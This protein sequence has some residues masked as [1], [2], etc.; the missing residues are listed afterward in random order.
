MGFL[1]AFK[2]RL[3]RVCEKPYKTFDFELMCKKYRQKDGSNLTFEGEETY[4]G[5]SINSPQKF[6]EDICNTKK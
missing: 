4:L 1:R 3:N 5:E 6:I 2:G